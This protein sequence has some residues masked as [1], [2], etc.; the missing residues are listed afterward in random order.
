MRTSI[1]AVAALAFSTPMQAQQISADIVLHSGPVRGHVIVGDAYSTYRRPAVVVYQ[2]PA[3][4]IVV[5]RFRH[6]RHHRHWKRHGYRQVTVYYR[7]GR[8]FDRYDRR[9]P[10]MREVMVYER[11]GRYYR[12][13]DECDRYERH[14]DWEHDRDYDRS[15]DRDDYRDRWDD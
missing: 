7:D 10:R 11:D 4:V 6:H 1:L 3:R 9:H 8:Y 2:R 15:H 12:H 13:C 14:H 5:E